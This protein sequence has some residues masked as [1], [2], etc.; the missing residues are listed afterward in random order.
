MPSEMINNFGINVGLL[1]KAE[2]VKRHNLQLVIQVLNKYYNIITIHNIT[3]N[4]TS[5]IFKHHKL[6]KKTQILPR[7]RIIQHR[8]NNSK[9][10]ENLAWICKKLK[11][12][13]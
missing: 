10:I 2:S 9:N 3:I 13:P 8:E 4:T 6:L 11:R 7:F 5:V 12:D 1:M